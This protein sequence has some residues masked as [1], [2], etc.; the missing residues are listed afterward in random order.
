MTTDLKA[1]NQYEIDLNSYE[2]W[3]GFT[4]FI[5]CFVT[6]SLKI[7]IVALTEPLCYIFRV[8]KKCSR[9]IVSG[10]VKEREFFYLSQYLVNKILDSTN[11]SR[12]LK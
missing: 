5:Q 1:R 7:L 3:F 6:D 10:N 4:T 12:Q 11:V 8:E 2:K 9:Y